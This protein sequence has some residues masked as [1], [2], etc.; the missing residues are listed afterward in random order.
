MFDEW[1]KKSVKYNMKKNDLMY[2]CE[3]YW[4]ENL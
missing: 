2:V 4:K 1:I 3:V